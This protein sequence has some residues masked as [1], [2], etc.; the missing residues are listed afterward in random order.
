MNE[1]QLI[2]NNFITTVKKFLKK[3]LS[4]GLYLVKYLWELSI[5]NILKY[6]LTFKIKVL[7]K[8]W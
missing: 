8:K 1:I 6:K 2:L 7:K 5:V 4:L 3:I